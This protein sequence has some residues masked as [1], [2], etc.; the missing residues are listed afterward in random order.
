M[1][2]LP[3]SLVRGMDPRF[4]FRTKMSRIRNTAPRETISLISRAQEKWMSD[5]ERRPLLS[6]SSSSSY[7]HQHQHNRGHS[8][9]YRTLS[10]EDSLTGVSDQ[11]R[12]GVWI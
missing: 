12:K 10:R 7:Q 6:S 8:H 1:D 3:D 9:D 4:R 11:V 2:P 5:G